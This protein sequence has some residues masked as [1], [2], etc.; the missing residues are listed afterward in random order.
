[1]EFDGFRL[2]LKSIQFSGHGFIGSIHPLGVLA[3]S[4]RHGRQGQNP[5][6]ELA[7]Q[8]EA[9]GWCESVEC[10]RALGGTHRACT[11]TQR[12]TVEKRP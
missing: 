2:V 4:T 7:T 1:M 9:F 10:A 3:A 6:N 5:S 11:H 8:D 12:H